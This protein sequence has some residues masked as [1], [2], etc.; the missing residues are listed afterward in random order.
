[1]NGAKMATDEPRDLEPN[2]IG[3]DINRGKG[4]HEAR[5]TVY[6]RSGAQ[7]LRAGHGLP[8]EIPPSA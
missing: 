8:V 7:S 1:V 2:G 4:R 6:M 5:E 3:S